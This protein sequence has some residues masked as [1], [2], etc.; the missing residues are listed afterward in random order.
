MG[1]VFFIQFPKPKT[2]LEKYERWIK[3]CRRQKEQFNISR[4][5]KDT[6]IC[7]KRFVGGNGQTVDHPNPIP[8]TTIGEQVRKFCKPPCKTPT[9]RLTST[10]LKR[11][12]L[13]TDD[14]MAAEALVDM[15][16]IGNA[17]DFSQKIKDS[18]DISEL[19]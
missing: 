13:D 8:A 16:V 18:F 1:G 7:S 5:T 11:K 14:M 4:V 2:Q 15:S 6:F 19:P 12:R 9:P 10:P 17:A 3:N